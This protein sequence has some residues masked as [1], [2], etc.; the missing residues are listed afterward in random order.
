MS[1]QNV[2]QLISP[3]LD[4]RLAAEEREAVLQHLTDCR[5]CNAR[6]ELLAEMRVALRRMQQPPVP[7][8]LATQLYITASKERVRL[9]SRRSLRQWVAFWAGNLRITL[10][11]LMR[12]LAV[13]FAG[14]VFSAFVIFGTLMPTLATQRITGLDVPIALFTDPTLEEVGHSHTTVNDTVLELTVDERGR[15]TDYSNLEG[16]L[17]PEMENDLLFYR[18]SPA[19][20]FGQPTWGKVTVT[21][22]RSNGGSHIVVRG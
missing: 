22:R 8:Q 21:F 17:T 9:L 12:P 16:K 13:P 5:E 20:A 14:G 6:A 10:D 19:T 4:Q 2:Q 11:N 7:P 18:F 1:C 3:L 15:V